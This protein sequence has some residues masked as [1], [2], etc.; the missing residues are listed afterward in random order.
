MLNGNIKCFESNLVAIKSLEGNRC[1]EFT[2]FVAC[3]NSS[4]KEHNFAENIHLYYYYTIRRHAPVIR[5]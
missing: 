2:W 3:G 1:I 5:P 4:E